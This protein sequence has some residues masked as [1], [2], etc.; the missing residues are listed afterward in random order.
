[1]VRVTVTGTQDRTV[2]YAQ[3]DQTNGISNNT[4]AIPKATATP[5]QSLERQ[6]PPR[7]MTKQESMLPREAYDALKCKRTLRFNQGQ[8]EDKETNDKS[9][10]TMVRTTATGTQDTT[11]H[12]ENTHLEQTNHAK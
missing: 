11:V 8:P 2:E 10:D 12:Q 1:M 3:L 5:T 4:L 6:R 9:V 7:M